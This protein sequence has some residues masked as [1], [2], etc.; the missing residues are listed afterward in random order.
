VSKGIIQSMKALK[1]YLE[2]AMPDLKEVL[3]EWPE[4]NE[5]LEYPALSMMQGNPQYTNMFPEFL[6]KTDLDDD[7]LTTSDW[8]V[9]M[10]DWKVQ[11]DLWCGSKTERNDLSD[12]L[13]QALNPDVVNPDGV[14][15]GL[16]LQLADYYNIWA[17]FDIADQRIEDSEVESQRREWRIQ[18]TLLAN[19][20]QVVSRTDSGIETIENG[21]LIVDNIPSS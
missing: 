18:F 9:G 19:V 20:R 4:A 8:V 1:S 17:R 13:F 10:W 6:A 15:N 12:K 16:G 3:D 5:Q 11:L 14:K 2:T 21:L 7:K